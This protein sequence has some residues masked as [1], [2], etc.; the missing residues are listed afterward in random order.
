MKIKVIKK[1]EVKPIEIKVE[2]KVEKTTNNW[3][4]ESQNNIADLKRKDEIIRFNNF[5]K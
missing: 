1:G 4:K 3:L 5:G 2:P